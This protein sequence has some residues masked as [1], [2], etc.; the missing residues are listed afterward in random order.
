MKP[1]DR[2]LLWAAVVLAACSLAWNVGMA[3]RQPDARLIAAVT[4]SLSRE[5]AARDVA[6][7]VL[8]AQVEQLQG[9][10][11]TSPAP[12]PSENPRGR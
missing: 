5:I 6:I 12:T 3:L 4:V 2:M 1:T 9:R 7:A 8:R 11:G 10:A